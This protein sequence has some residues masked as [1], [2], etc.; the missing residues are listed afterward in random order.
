MHFLQDQNVKGIQP[1]AESRCG[2]A[3]LRGN[4]MSPAVAAARNT[5]PLPRRTSLIRPRGR[6]QLTCRRQALSPPPSSTPTSRHPTSARQLGGACAS[7]LRALLRAAT[8]APAGREAGLGQRAPVVAASPR[9]AARGSG[10]K[11]LRAGVALQGFRTSIDPA[12]MGRR[13]EARFGTPRASSDPEARNLRNPSH[14]ENIG[15]PPTSL[16]PASLSVAMPAP[17]G[18]TMVERIESIRK[19]PEEILLRASWRLAPRQTWRDP[20]LPHGYLAQARP[21]LAN[22][23]HFGLKCGCEVA[24]IGPNLD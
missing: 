18:P 8:V 15:G 20:A 21:M 12:G 22:S 17:E 13:D 2:G 3:T 5:T 23:G 9:P 24:N 14:E 19:S 10:P 16:A 6:R 11:C 4:P 1:V 7:R